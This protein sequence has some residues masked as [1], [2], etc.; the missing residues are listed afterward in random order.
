[1]DI[2]GLFGSRLGSAPAVIIGNLRCRGGST[3]ALTICRCR[4]E[5]IGSDVQ[6]QRVWTTR[7]ELFTDLN[8]RTRFGDSK[9]CFNQLGE[10]GE[11]R[12]RTANCVAVESSVRICHYFKRP[13]RPV[14][15]A[16]SV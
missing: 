3:Q 8:R 4:I 6:H 13:V 11:I 5:P 9:L 2:S 1:M 15:F 7:R 10:P 16:L 14:M 12:Q